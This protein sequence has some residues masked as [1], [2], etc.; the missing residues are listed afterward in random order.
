MFIFVLVFLACVA[1]NGYLKSG[2]FGAAALLKLY[3]IIAM[4]IDSTRRPI[5][6]RAAAVLAI[7]FVVALILLQWHDVGAYSA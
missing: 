4:M 1:T 5:K 6:E 2:L 7:L 3:P